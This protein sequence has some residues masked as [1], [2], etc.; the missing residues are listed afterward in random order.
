M[1]WTCLNPSSCTQRMFAVTIALLFWQIS[2]RCCSWQQLMFID[3]RNV[4]E[5]TFKG[6]ESLP[7]QGQWNNTKI[8][9]LVLGDLRWWQRGPGAWRVTLT[10]VR[11]MRAS[12]PRTATRSTRT[13][14]AT[15]SHGSWAWK[16]IMLNYNNL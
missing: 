11:F 7:I 9:H 15:F 12:G 6:F 1:F 16:L 14:L 8:G 2:Y 13:Y 3:P 4:V 5:S 10:T